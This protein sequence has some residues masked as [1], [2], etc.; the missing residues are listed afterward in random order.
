M[1][2]IFKLFGWLFSNLILI[3]VVL[4][5][6]Y[7]YV[8]WDDPFAAD[9][10]AGKLM[11][12]FPDEISEMRS[13]VG[14]LALPDDD[15]DDDSS[16]VAAAESSAMA[17]SPQSEAVPAVEQGSDYA[18]AATD[19][20]VT[21]QPEVATTAGEMAAAPAA[22]S[23]VYVTPEIE[24]ALSQLQN[25]G[26]IDDV[27]TML[28]ADKPATQ[29]MIDARKAFYKRDYAASVAAYKELI[30]KDKDNFDALGELGN[31][32]FTQ[33][34]MQQAADAYYRAATIMVS[35]GKAQRAASLIGFLASVDAEK[36]K[37][38]GEMLVTDDNGNGAL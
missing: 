34:E 24:D 5:L 19:A 31:V 35:Q 6:C 16:T 36:A 27:T 4:A 23:D 17:V 20:A 33:G 12:K 28:Q 25:D 10:P 1:N 8:Y 14:G 26:S 3:L 9:T 15:S 11:A 32:Y 21:S 37:K 30:A 18:P 29:L 22:D 2:F 38:L 13:F 7:A